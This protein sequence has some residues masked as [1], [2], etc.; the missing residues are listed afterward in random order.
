MPTWK[1]SEVR[2]SLTHTEKGLAPQLKCLDVS[3]ELNQDLAKGQRP[4]RVTILIRVVNHGWI[5]NSG[6][7]QNLSFAGLAA[8][9]R[10]WKLSK[11]YPSPTMAHH[12]QLASRLA[13]AS[14]RPGRLG[15]S[16]RASG[17]QLP[18]RRHLDTCET[19]VLFKTATTPLFTL[20]GRHE[21]EAHRSRDISTRSWRIEKMRGN[22]QE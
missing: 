22:W 20:Y 15:Q 7:Q 10:R 9:F 6:R 18:V 11:H 8:V 14:D 5:D 3:V 17:P 2:P 16:A 13:P 19:L 1:G 4:R 12:K 21:P